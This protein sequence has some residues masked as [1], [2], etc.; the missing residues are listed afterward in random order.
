MFGI[1]WQTFVAR[2]KVVLDTFGTCLRHQ[3][4]SLESELLG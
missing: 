4:A 1:T 2:G 3:W